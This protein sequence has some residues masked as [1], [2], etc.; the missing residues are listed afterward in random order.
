MFEPPFH[1][2][3]HRKNQH[4]PLHR[5]SPRTR[6]SSFECPRPALGTHSRPPQL[7]DSGVGGCDSTEAKQEV[8]SVFFRFLCVFLSVLSVFMFFLSIFM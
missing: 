8:L 3:S 4:A 5:P 1:P 6:A 2:T 7:H